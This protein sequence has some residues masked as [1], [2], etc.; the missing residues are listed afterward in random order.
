MATAIDTR[1]QAI[2]DAIDSIITGGA[3]R[4]NEINGRSVARYKLSE[5]SE[6]RKDLLKQKAAAVGGVRNY[7][8]F[9]SPEAGVSTDM[10]S[11]L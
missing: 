6:L 7:T 10:S 9:D 5:L 4:E 3:V 2:D 1:I 11:G 8:D